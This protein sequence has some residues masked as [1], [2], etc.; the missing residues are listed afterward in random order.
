MFKLLAYLL[1]SILGVV[2]LS[3]CSTS[4]GNHLTKSNTNEIVQY[5]NLIHAADAEGYYLIGRNYQ[6]KGNF[7]LAIVAYEKAIQLEGKNTKYLSALA[8]V[9]ADKKMYPQA[10]EKF[11][12]IISSEMSSTNLNNL[13]YAY[14]LSGDYELAENAVNQALAF[15]PEYF[16]AK[17]NM[18]KILEKKVVENQA[19]ISEAFDENNTLA[20]N[21]NELKG[22]E[23]IKN[24]SLEAI[25]KNDYASIAENL[26]NNIDE[27]KQDLV[28]LDANQ[29]DEKIH[30]L[31]DKLLF[32]EAEVKEISNDIA[33]VQKSNNVFDITY[34]TTDQ[35]KTANVIAA[36]LNKNQSVINFK[37]DQ[38]FG[39]VEILN[40]NGIGGFAKKVKDD[41]LD[42]KIVSNIKI[43]NANHFMH[44]RTIVEYR[45]GYADLALE[46]ATNISKDAEVK[47]S[48][49]LPSKLSVRATVGKDS[50][51]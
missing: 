2:Y 31:Q 13:G 5:S 49:D 23:T 43:K 20:Q 11:K 8:S 37:Y 47:L 30:N 26:K 33:V 27:I 32:L 3:G 22:E 21:E 16:T 25:E 38:R 39:Y 7:D 12:Q 50:F 10:I 41:L 15:D 28:T 48:W 42:K 14:Y 34:V 18:V 24:T 4:A 44:R 36:N 17:K 19:K 9:Y 40:G 46:L 6:T 45:P 29:K 51:I 35:P 1:T